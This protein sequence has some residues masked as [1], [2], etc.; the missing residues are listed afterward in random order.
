M[1]A[2]LFLIFDLTGTFAFAVSGA[3]AARQNQLDIFGIGVIAFLTAC[4]GGI[5]RDICLGS[6]PPAGLMNHNYFLITLLALFLAVFLYRF[7]SKL[8][9]PVLVFDAFGL[10]F[11]SV[12]GAQKALHLG[13]NAEVAILLGM[14]TACGGGMLRDVL[15][16][17]VPVVLRREIYASAALLASSLVVLGNYL[18]WN[19]ILKTWLPL[20]SCIGLRLLS[21]KF[22]L[23]LPSFAEK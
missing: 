19:Q 21:I 15:L 13:A 11:F 6:T 1:E 22:K 8:E 20:L 18:E 4:G 9:H 12:A 17:R 23:N 3:V 16:T 2:I 10:G 7:I 5:I 14:I